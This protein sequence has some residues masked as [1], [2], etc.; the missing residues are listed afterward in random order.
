M[1]DNNNAATTGDKQIKVT[2]L[3]SPIRS[4]GNHKD[5]I[6]SLGLHHIN[7]SHTLPD[8][9]AVRGMVATVRQWVKVEEI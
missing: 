3:K 5:T 7:D 1:S 9:P 2:L 4:R 8:N 6:K